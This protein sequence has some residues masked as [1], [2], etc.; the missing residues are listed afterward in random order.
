[1]VVDVQGTTAA[2]SLD[3]HDAVMEEKIVQLQHQ[4]EQE[5][6]KILKQQ[7][8][9]RASLDDR[10]QTKLKCVNEAAEAQKASALTQAAKRSFQ[11]AQLL[12]QAQAAAVV[13][14]T[15]ATQ[16]RTTDGKQFTYAVRGSSEPHLRGS[17]PR[18]IFDAEPDSMLAQMY[19]GEWKYPC[20]EDGRA[21]V[22]SNPAHWLQILDWL[23]FG[24][25]PASPS[26]EL[27]QQCRFWQ[28]TNL[29]AQID[30]PPKPIAIGDPAPE[31]VDHAAGSIT[32]SKPDICDILI[33]FDSQDCKARFKAEGCIHQFVQHSQ[34]SERADT[35]AWSA[36]GHPWTLHCKGWLLVLE[37]RDSELRGI[38]DFSV[39]LTMG[40]PEKP[41]RLL[42]ENR[43][44]AAFLQDYV[45]EC[46]LG[47]DLFVPPNVD[48]RGS[49]WV[50]LTVTYL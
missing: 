27:V 12:R 24:S 9:L 1:M 38:R 47:D 44:N 26:P 14:A 49:T 28:L 7:S 20:D 40:N 18:C 37:T 29:L 45:G 4:H 31:P 30:P 41:V 8:Q 33:R 50:S 34:M 17:V 6:Q 21:L 35:I 42:N 11:E 25:V 36:F 10:H 3:Q 16:K 39:V 2:I 15:Q 46:F 48:Y 32:I 43:C 13:E 5:I 19:N 22:N 23:S